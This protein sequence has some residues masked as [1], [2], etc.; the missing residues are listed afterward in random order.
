MSTPH[1]NRVSLFSTLAVKGALDFTIL[2]RYERDSGARAESTFDPTN[3]LLDKIESGARPDVMIG[4]SSSFDSLVSAGIIDGLSRKSI[5]RTGVGLAVPPETPTPDISS[6]EALAST[7]KQA[8]SVAYSRTG[9]SGVYFAELLLALGISDE[10]NSRATIVEKGFTALAVVDGRADLAIQQ[11][12]ELRFV[13]EVQIVGP[14]PESVQHY[15]E[16][17]AAL[18]THAVGDR[19][20]TA[21]ITALTTDYARTAYADAGLEVR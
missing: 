18:G 17:S 9:A 21:L 20:A 7:L 2:P 12:S 8:R 5:A 4:V 19:N 15:T 3:V 16:F 13:P 6:P 1:D 11:L 14:L 10:V